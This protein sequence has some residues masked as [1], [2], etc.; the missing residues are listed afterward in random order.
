MDALP[1]W[2]LGRKTPVGQ[3][4]TGKSF[5]DALGITSALVQ[6]SSSFPN[7][8]LVVLSGQCDP[9]TLTGNY[10]QIDQYETSG[11][12]NAISNLGTKSMN[13]AQYSISTFL[14]TLSIFAPITSYIAIDSVE[15]QFGNA[16]PRI[17]SYLSISGSI[18]KLFVSC[19]T[20]N[21]SQITTN[22]LSCVMPLIVYH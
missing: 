17:Q 8:E 4:P 6:L 22:V 14:A 16:T 1:I 19:A 12:I 3:S 15:Q 21:A 9:R 7:T 13:F 10:T 20:G 18:I 5:M 11:P 2:K